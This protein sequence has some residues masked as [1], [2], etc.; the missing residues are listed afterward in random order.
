VKRLPVDRGFANWR[1]A[2]PVAGRDQYPSLAYVLLHSISHIMMQQITVD[3]GY[4]LT[5]LKER[6]YAVGGRYGI[7]LY[8]SSSDAEGTLG[9]LVN[10]GR[11]IVEH[12]AMA[13][14]SAQLCS[15]DPVCAEHD[16]ATD[17]GRELS[18]AA[19]HGCL[20]LPETSCEIRNDFLDRA[21]VVQTIQDAEAAFFGAV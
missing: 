8:T 3:C 15:N 16:P 4:P 20:F 10:S 6:I 19:C 11:R 13:I 18:G 14:R 12:L 7:L 2:H 1:Q 21:L 5:S 9:G 17:E